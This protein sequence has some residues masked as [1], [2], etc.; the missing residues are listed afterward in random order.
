M[1][2][3]EIR[4]QTHP[5]ASEI[6]NAYIDFSAMTCSLVAVVTD[7]IRDGRPVVGYGFNSNGRYSPGP[8]L[9]DRFIPRLQSAAPDSLLDDA[10]EN[11]DPHRIWAAMMANEKPGGH[12]ERSVAVG[13]VDMAVWERV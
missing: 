12:G 1:R 10:G 9:R 13:V 5:I 7:V 2:I 6:R 3:V 11:L 4:E 8:L